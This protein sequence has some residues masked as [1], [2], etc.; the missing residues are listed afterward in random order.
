MP[1]DT[2]VEEKLRKLE[3]EVRATRAANPP[4][5]PAEPAAPAPARVAPAPMRAVAPEPRSEKKPGFLARWWGGKSWKT[6]L[7]L[8]GGAVLGGAI[9]LWIAGKILRLAL[10][11]GVAAAIAYGV[12]W[13]LRKRKP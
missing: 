13:V 11:L 2:E 12:W 3:A 8:L 1:T 9:T 6:K 7:L 10:Y 4:P 5:R